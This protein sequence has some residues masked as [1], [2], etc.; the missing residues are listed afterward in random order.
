MYCIANPLLDSEPPPPPT[1]MT[2][3]A[4]ALAVPP[5]ILDTDL[6]KVGFGT[7]LVVVISSF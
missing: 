4:A 5:S 1:T 2:T 3:P 6:Y 7:R